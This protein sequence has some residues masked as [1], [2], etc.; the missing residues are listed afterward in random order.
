MGLARRHLHHATVGA[1]LAAAL[2][3]ST[4]VPGAMAQEEIEGEHEFSYDPHAENGPDGWGE[5][6]PE[7]ATCSDG[8]WQSPIDLY[9][10]RA[11]RRD[12]GYLNYSYKPAEASIVNRGHDIMVKFK[13]DAGSL[14][15][16]GTVYHLKQLHWHTPTEHALNGHRFSMELHMVHQTPEKK[17]AVVGILYRVS[18]LADPFLKSL[19]PAIERLRGKEEPIGKVNPNHVGLTGS[20]YFRYMGSLTTPPCTEGIIWTVIPTLRLVASD[21]LDLLREAV[22]DGFEMNA[23]PLQD[24]NHRTIWFSITCP[25]EPHVYV[26]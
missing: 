6:K 19:Q 20:S 7:W 3:L 5:I 17:T 2:L 24:V 21:Q 4:A 15:I 11:I 8:R 13:G 25:A 18:N 1:L 26:E 22:D 23:R 12:L 10:H 14:V 16:D 9:H